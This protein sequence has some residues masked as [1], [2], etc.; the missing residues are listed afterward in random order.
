MLILAN[1]AVFYQKVSNWT[2]A[3]RLNRQITTCLLMVFLAGWPGATVVSAESVQT[4]NSASHIDGDASGAIDY[5][6]DHSTIRAAAPLD[7]GMIELQ[8]VASGLASPVGITHAGDGSGRLFIIERAGRIRILDKTGVLPTPFLDIQ[9]IVTQSGGEEGLLALAFHPN[10]ETNRQFYTMH[11]NLSGNLALSRFTTSATNPDQAPASSRVE[12]LVIPH[13][14]NGNHNGGTLAFG[15]D[16]Y[17]YWSTG[18]GGGGG[19]PSNNAQNLNSLLGKILRLDID[20]ASPYAIPPTNPFY[21]NPSPSVRK[22]I[23]AYGLRNPWRIAFDRLTHD[24]YIGD[25][26]QSAREEIDF[27]PSSSLGGEDYGWRV[28]EGSI[29]YN[30]SS[31]CDQSGKVLPVAEYDH[32]AGC[33][34]TGGYVYRGIDFPSLQGHYFYADFCQG[35]LYDLYRDGSSNWISTLLLDTPYNISTF[36]EDEDGELYFAN[37]SNGRIYRIRYQETPSGTPPDNDLISAPRVV[38]GIPDEDTLDATGATIAGGDAAV[39]SCNLTPGIGSVWYSFAPSAS[40]EVNFDTFG[41]NYDTFIA[42]WTGTPGNLSPVACNDDDPRSRLQSAVGFDAVGGTTYYLEIGEWDRYLNGASGISSIPSSDGMV[43]ADKQLELHGTTFQDVPGTQQHWLYIE[44]LWD[45]GLTA[46]CS[47]DP[48]MYC[49]NLILDRAQA[50]VFMLRGQFGTSYVPPLPPWN[51]FLADDW[52][53]S[54]ISYAQKWAE[55]M[56]QED[57]TAGCQTNPLMYC[58]RRQLPRV[59]ASVFGLNMMH[60]VTYSPPPATGTVFADMTDVNYYGTKW[61]EQAYADGLLP[62]CGMQGSQPLY[63][64]DDLVSRAWA[65]YLIVQA[66]GLTLPTP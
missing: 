24:L 23:W 49:P 29:C 20:S 15:S 8:E 9:S 26:G 2:V 25:V 64:P 63:C 54:D 18:D 56:W 47:T 19:D 31:G 58:P 13:P 35:T 46:G 21:S 43:H 51:T 37:L 44:A 50:A 28:M 4:Q 7:A 17:L 30:P 5:S 62:N 39:S 61:A 60:G 48:L 32:G 41:S 40:G 59:E 22:E 6:A 27:Q 38:P 14:S 16:G 53:L 33:S 1:L 52:S 11:V 10:Y 45:A 3:V 36:G 66:K 65:A 55:G 34:V 57:L 12:L 42:V